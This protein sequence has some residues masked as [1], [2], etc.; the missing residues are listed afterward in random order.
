MQMNFSFEKPTSKGWIHAGAHT[1]DLEALPKDHY[2]PRG[3]WVFE[4]P[5]NMGIQPGWR[6]RLKAGK[7]WYV[8]IIVGSGEG[9]V[10]VT[11]LGQP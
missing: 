2:P 1:A 5:S 9:K 6:V 4:A 7:P 10:K 8:S 3:A 11:L